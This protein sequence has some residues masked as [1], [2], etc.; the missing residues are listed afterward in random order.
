MTKRLSNDERAALAAT[1]L[2]TL[3]VSV[4]RSAPSASAGTRL[5]TAL[6]AIRTTV[7]RDP[8]KATLATVAASAL[9]FYA[10]ERGH[11]PRV[12]TLDDALVYCS[13]A[14]SVGYD[15][16]FPVTPLGKR[17][18]AALMTLGPSLAARALDPPQRG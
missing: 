10:A 11:N 8:L 18:A 6:D 3:A 17:I 4:R 13:T 16:T 5:D 7:H 9:A 12:H 15:Q 1:V 14:L 2:A